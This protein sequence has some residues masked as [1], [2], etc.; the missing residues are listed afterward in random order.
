MTIDYEN[1]AET[2]LYGLAIE[3]NATVTNYVADKLRLLANEA[4]AEQKE[5]DIR[6]ADEFGI[7]DGEFTWLEVRGYT[8]TREGIIAA[9]R[10]GES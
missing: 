8:R 7:G 4:M 3:P 5:R 9:I 6:I 1:R 2:I 10:K